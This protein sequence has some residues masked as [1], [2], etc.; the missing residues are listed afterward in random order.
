MEEFDQE[1]E[2]QPREKTM[3]DK[4]EKMGIMKENAPNLEILK[5]KIDSLVRKLSKFK[6]LAEEGD[7][8][9][10]SKAELLDYL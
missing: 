10:K 1:D 3:I 6:E 2:N 5:E 7:S 9:E 8:R 4:L